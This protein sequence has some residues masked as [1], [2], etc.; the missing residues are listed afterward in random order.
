MNT[1]WLGFALVAIISCLSGCASARVVRSDPTS[2]VV[3]VPDQTNEWPF[4]YRDEAFKVAGQYVKDPVLMSSVR[5]KVGESVTS[6]QN[7]N[8]QDLGGKDNKPKFG[9]VT[10]TTSVTNVRDEYE[11]HLEF[12]G[13]QPLGGSTPPPIPSGQ[14]V[15]TIGTT[16]PAGW[17]QPPSASVGAPRKDNF[18][19]R[20]PPVVGSQS[21]TTPGGFPS[22]GLS[23]R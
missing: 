17:N 18:D 15:G 2:V 6:N 7:T 13:R 14:P 23:N 10:S 19:P 8:K 20:I 22:T 12:Q 5:V 16:Q 11:Y 4:H 3:A 1:R 9:E 21:N